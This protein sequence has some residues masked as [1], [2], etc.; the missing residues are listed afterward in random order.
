MDIPGMKGIVGGGIR[1]SCT[2]R[3]QD[4]IRNCRE[5]AAAD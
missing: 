1:G 4:D 3:L 2:G 5:G